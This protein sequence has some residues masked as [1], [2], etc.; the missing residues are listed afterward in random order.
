[1]SS[2]RL[3]AAAKYYQELPHQMAAWNWLQGKIPAPVIEEFTALYRAAQPPKPSGTPDAVTIAVQFLRSPGIEGCHLDAY[4]DPETGDQ[5]WTIGWGNTRINGR[6]VRKGD[7]ITQQQADDMLTET[8]RGIERTLAKTVPPWREL[9]TGQRAAL[10]SFAFNNGPRFMTS[11]GHQTIGRALRDGR[12]A[13]VPA[14]MMLYVNP[15]GPTEIGLRRRRKLEGEMWSA[16]SVG[17]PWT[18]ILSPE[19][20]YYSQ[21][22]NGAQRDRTCFASAAAMLAKQVKPS[23]LCGSNADLEQYLKIVN[24]FGDTTNASAQVRALGVLGIKARLNQASDWGTV[25][26]AIAS[27]SGIALGYIHRGP[28]T[29]PDPRSLGHWLYCWGISSTHIMVHDPMGE[30]DMVGGGFVLGKS[31]RSVKMTRRNFERRWMVTLSRGAWEFTPGTGWALEV[32][33]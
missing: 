13:D 29:A 7:T 33:Q 3:T 1:M 32:I 27:G 28:V 25:E 14:A 4:P 5:P 17:R 10:L 2:I 16:G 31:G 30:P 6:A 8:V 21:T 23:C 22:D 9:T 15:G 18:M 24:T 26:R 20:Q 12:L 19:P 11:G